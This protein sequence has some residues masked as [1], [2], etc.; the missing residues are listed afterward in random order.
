[1]T[2]QAALPRI[3]LVGPSVWP[4]EGVFSA[5]VSAVD[6]DGAIHVVTDGGA[7][8]VCDWLEG[9]LGLAVQLVPGDR[10]LMIVE[11]GSERPIVLGRIRSPGN[12]DAGVV[13]RTCV[14]RATESLSLKCGE[15]SI[16]LRSDGKIMIRGQDVLVRAKGTQRIRAGTVSIN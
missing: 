9:P 10:A 12:A 4:P 5:Q 14:V 16:D 8:L 6:T 2:K 1:M 11:A 13:S 7:R 3:E 15:S